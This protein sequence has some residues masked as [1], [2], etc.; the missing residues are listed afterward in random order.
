MDSRR[1]WKDVEATA[2]CPLCSE[3]LKDPKTLP[4]LHSFCLL[5]LNNLARIERGRHQ[6]EISC[7]ICQTSVL[8]PEEN[9]FSNFPT[10]FHLDRFKKILIVSNGNQMAITCQSCN[11]GK[12]AIS[13]CF[14]C[15][16]YL[17]SKCDKAHRRLRTTRDHRSILLQNGLIEDILH[18]PVT[19]AQ[20]YHEDEGLCYYCQQCNECICH[21]CCD[22]SHRQ[23][24]VVDIQIAAQQGTKRINKALEKAEKKM[25]ACQDEIEENEDILKR[26]NMEIGAARRNVKAIVKELIRNLKEHE[27]E[28]LTKTDDMYERQQKSHAIKQRKLELFIARLR[29]PVEL[30]KCVLKR[31]I[32]VEIMKEKGAIIDRCEDL[33]NS[34]ETKALELPFVSYIL[35]EEMCQSVQMSGPGKLIVSSADPSQTLASGE[36]L[37]ASVAGKKT[38]ILVRTRDTGGKQCYNEDDQVEVKIQ[39]PLG[40][41]LETAFEDKKDGKYKITFTPKFV[42]RHDVMV[43]VNGQ[44]LTDSPWSVQVTPH[45]YQMTFKLGTKIQDDEDEEVSPLHSLVYGDGKLYSPKDVAISQVNGNIAVLDILGVKLYDAN[46]KYLRQ[47]GT[48]CSGK[49]LKM[50]ESVAFSVS[51]DVM[52]IDRM[53]ITLCTEKG[54]FVRHFMKH[55]KD[56]HSI[57]VARDGRVIV[58]DSSDAQ[59]IVLSP[60]GEDSLQCFGDPYTYG[61]P[62]FAIHNQGKYFVSYRDEHCVSVFNGEGTLLYD[63]GTRGCSKERLNCPLGLPVDKFNN[64]IVCD[65]N[66]SRLQVFTL[67]GKHVT[68]ITGF[69]SPQFV[70]VSEDGQLY[71]T[72]KEKECVHVLH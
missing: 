13:Y 33:L 61:S 45:Q 48:K 25:I 22:E 42:G 34:K 26:R 55:T 5:C 38:K 31:N 6:D 39:S 15:E 41:E 18:R 30:G 27:K 69:G 7:P 62:S 23:H 12:T 40:K 3:T 47:F 63:I 66:A 37:T 68:T 20:E 29:S 50:P 60:N 67:E 19:C 56:P 58:C 21:I 14:V 53:K 65:S 59:V 4:C 16:D 36:G 57:S 46:G 72:D 8:I 35:D 64:L 54:S 71:V 11:E 51:G 17:C 28:V 2:K 52:V 43:N 44:P 10:S 70:A 49:R 9:T 1:C 24:H 32:D